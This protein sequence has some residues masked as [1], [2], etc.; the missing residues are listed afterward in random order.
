MKH[1]Q[2]P[3]ISSEIKN[4]LQSGFKPQASLYKWT[5]LEFQL[6]IAIYRIALWFEVN[7]DLG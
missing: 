7:L 6:M 3:I 5:M 1:K 2:F 4:E